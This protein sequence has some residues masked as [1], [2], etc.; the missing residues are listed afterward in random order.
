MKILDWIPFEKINWF[1]LSRN[2][3]AIPILEKNLDK[4]D[5]ICLS[6]NPNAIPILEKNLDK[7]NWIGLSRN[8]NAIH[9]LE[10]NLDKIDW[11][12]LFQNPNIFTYDYKA[13][14]ND[15]YKEGG[16]A[17]ELMKNR[18][19]PKNMDKWDGDSSKTSTNKR[20]IKNVKLIID[21]KFI[22]IL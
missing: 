21:N 4:I 10:K 17:D 14:K 7:V 2:P 5:W 1:Y 22:K 12:Y 6:A 20:F 9:I 8:P 19:H 3:N 18:F 11:S 13:I 15:M 16:I